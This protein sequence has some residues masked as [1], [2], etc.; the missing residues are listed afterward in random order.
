M[1]NNSLPGTRYIGGI[2]TRKTT[3]NQREIGSAR[4]LQRRKKNLLIWRRIA[5]VRMLQ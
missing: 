3:E 5:Y 1:E 2:E 4:P